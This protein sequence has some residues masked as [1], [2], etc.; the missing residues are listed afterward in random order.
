[1][2]INTILFLLTYIECVA[3]A[4]NCLPDSIG[5]DS[6]QIRCGKLASAAAWDGS[7]DCTAGCNLGTRQC[8]NSD[9]A[10]AF[11]NQGASVFCLDG[12]YLDVFKGESLGTSMNYMLLA[13]T[14]AVVADAA[15][16]AGM[17]CKGKNYHAISS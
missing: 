1:M 4:S 11:V 14:V 15:D 3:N 17:Q 16:N 7:D 5:D 12:W 8:W 2:Y 9:A 6:A 13:D 10:N